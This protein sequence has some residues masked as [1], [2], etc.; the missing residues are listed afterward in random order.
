MFMGIFFFRLRKFSCII[1]LIFTG[2]LSWEFSL[3]SIPIL[4]L[5]LVFSLCP[6]FYECFGLGSFCILHFAFPL[7]VVS[8]FSMESSVPEILSSISCIL[9]VMLTSMTP[10]LFRRFSVSRVVS[11]CDFFIVSISLFIS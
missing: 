9:L 11:L 3:S 2:S 10:D 1:L 8:M 6:R 4:S 7:T 5:G